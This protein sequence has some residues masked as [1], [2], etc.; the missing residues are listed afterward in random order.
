[1]RDWLARTK[2]ERTA[3]R[4]RQEREAREARQ[5][6][7][8]E[9]LAPLIAEVDEFYA[10]RK[11]EREQDRELRAEISRALANARTPSPRKVRSLK[12]KLRWQQRHAFETPTEASP[13][14][15][16]TLDA[17]PRPDIATPPLAPKDGASVPSTWT[18][19]VGGASYCLHGLTMCGI[20]SPLKGVHP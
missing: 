8:A 3:K 19:S 5:R 20:C 7:K 4:E 2:P 15:P 17:T 6:E 14:P 13:E 10:Q 18:T 16:A 12:N 9:R 11:V 1:M